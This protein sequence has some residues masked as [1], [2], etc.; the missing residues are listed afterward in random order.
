MAN[1]QEQSVAMTAPL[2]SRRRRRSTPSNRSRGSSKSQRARP[3]ALARDG[4]LAEASEISYGSSPTSSARSK[5][6]PAVLDELQKTQRFLKEEVDA[7]DVA[8]VVSRATGVPVSRSSKVRWR[9]SFRMEDALH[10]RVI[11]QDE[12]V[13][14]VANA[15]RRQPGRTFGPPIVPSARSSFWGRRAWVRTELAR[16]LAE[17][18]ST[19]PEPWSAST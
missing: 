2:A 19:T 12:A 18:C 14:A 10:A 11:G 8:E 4:N 9:S 5:R 17:F 6:P 16:A 7:E 15:I 13:S 1:L 3:S